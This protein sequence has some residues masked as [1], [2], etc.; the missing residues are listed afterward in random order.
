MSM[1]TPFEEVIVELL[2]ATPHLAI[3]EIT[4]LFHCY[5]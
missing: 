3:L 2:P 4:G 1:E 5:F